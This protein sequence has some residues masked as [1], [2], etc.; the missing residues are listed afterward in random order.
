MAS[1]EG[2]QSHVQ[3]DGGS[4]QAHQIRRQPVRQHSQSPRP[5]RS[6]VSNGARSARNGAL[7][8]VLRGRQSARTR[9]R[10]L[11]PCPAQARCGNTAGCRAA[12]ITRCGYCEFKQRPTLD[13]SGTCRGPVKLKA[14]SVPAAGEPFLKFP[15]SNL[16]ERSARGYLVHTI[17]TACP[18]ACPP[19]RIRPT[20]RSAHE[21]FYFQAF[22]RSVSL[23]AAGYHY[24][25]VWTPSVGGT[26]TRENG[27]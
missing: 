12:A 2:G 13:A 3:T 11:T 16:R 15:I 17:V 10:R 18:V 22:N 19:V 26:F 7:N 27:S 6:G 21:G 20:L 25:S 1:L 14:A 8:G 4:R 5:A 24:N 23:L 9:T